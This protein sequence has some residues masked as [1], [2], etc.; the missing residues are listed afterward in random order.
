MV[1]LT[2][3]VRRLP[4]STDGARAGRDAGVLAAGRSRKTIAATG[5]WLKFANRLAAATFVG[6]AC[7]LTLQEPR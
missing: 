6:L 4:Q 7:R 2:S 5:G 3:I 1:E